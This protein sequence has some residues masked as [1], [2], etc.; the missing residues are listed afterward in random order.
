MSGACTGPEVELE[1]RGADDD[2]ALAV[3]NDARAR[4]LVEV[5]ELANAGD[6]VCVVHHMPRF[7]D[8]LLILPGSTTADSVTE[9]HVKMISA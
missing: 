8:E 6:D 4:P 5:D 3:N 2:G 7:R 9:H 1:G